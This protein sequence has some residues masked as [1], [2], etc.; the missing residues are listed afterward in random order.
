MGVLVDENGIV[1]ARQG[2]FDAESMKKAADAFLAAMPDRRHDNHVMGSGD[3]DETQPTTDGNIEQVKA[4]VG[5]S[6]DLVKKVFPY[7]PR[8]RT[9][10]MT[11]LHYAVG[12]EYPQSQHPDIVRFLIEQGADVNK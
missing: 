3:F 12:T 7:W 11:L 2:W 1:L 5:G 4:Q 6:P 8:G 9:G 10:G